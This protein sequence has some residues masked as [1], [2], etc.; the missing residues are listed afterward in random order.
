MNEREIWNRLI[1]LFLTFLIISISF[2]SLPP[3]LHI[4]PLSFW[5]SPWL[6]CFGQP[7]N[8]ISCLVIFAE[9]IS[10][11]FLLC[12]IPGRASQ[13]KSYLPIWVGVCVL[14]A[15]RVRW[16]LSGKHYSGNDAMITLTLLNTAVNYLTTC[17]ERRGKQA[18]TDFPDWATV[19][20]LAVDDDMAA[21]NAM[22][23]TTPGSVSTPI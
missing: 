20:L 17:L 5:I 2:H 3:R 19:S 16:C 9:V 7:M 15:G 4:L 6:P 22:M 23:R 14:I 10:G 13:A 18:S 8:T 11:P 1:S 12:S 21:S